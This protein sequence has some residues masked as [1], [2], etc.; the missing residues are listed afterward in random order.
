MVA[1]TCKDEGNTW[2]CLSGLV[3]LRWDRELVTGGTSK[4]VTTRTRS[5][6]WTNQVEEVVS[7]DGPVARL[8]VACAGA[9]GNA[10]RAR[11][12]A[13]DQMT[14]FETGQLS[15]GVR[16]QDESAA[17]RDDPGRVLTDASAG[18]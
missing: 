11:K 18:L 17:D 5:C 6:D 3:S 9:D 4:E 14:L 16:A 12:S 1:R 2:P 8:R 7:A 13:S 10:L 15:V